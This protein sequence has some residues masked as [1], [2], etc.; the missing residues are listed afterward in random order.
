MTELE[1]KVGAKEEELKNNEIELVARNERFERAQ[2]EIG[3]LKGELVKLHADNK[4][5]QDHLGE[6][7]AE[8]KV[9]TA[10]EVSEYQSSVEMVALKQTIR[11]EVIEEAI[12]SFAYTT[13]IQH[14]DWDLAY[15]G[16][17]LAA[18][19]VEWRTE[20]Q[21][22]QPFPEERPGRPLSPAAELQEVPPPP[23][24]EGLLEHVI[25]GDQ[26]PTIRATESD[27]SIEQIDNPAGVLDRQE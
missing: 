14:P 21:A 26:E 7:K 9:A 5:L 10:K 6:A 3:L 25:K 23:P 8:A 1:N 2:V 17:H 11:D 16:D 15:L 22:N 20:L 27:R 19:I 24:P 18:H 4:S 12:E 13:E